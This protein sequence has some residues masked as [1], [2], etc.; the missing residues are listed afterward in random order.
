TGTPPIGSM[1]TNIVMNTRQKN[2]PTWPSAGHLAL[3]PMGPALA[4]SG[5]FLS[6]AAGPLPE[7]PHHQPDQGDADDDADGAEVLLDRGPVRPHRISH[8]GQG[9]GPRQA[10]GDRVDREL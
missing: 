9:E 2:V 6:P 10:A 4:L 7:P 5:P 8:S 3:S 1:I